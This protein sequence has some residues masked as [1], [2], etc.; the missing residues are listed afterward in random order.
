MVSRGVAYSTGQLRKNLL[1][2][3]VLIDRVFF[4]PHLVNLTLAPGAQVVVVPT[5]RPVNEPGKRPAAVNTP[6]LSGGNAPLLGPPLLL[7]A[8]TPRP[9]FFNSYTTPAGG[10]KQFPGVG[11]RAA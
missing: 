6:K 10:Y 9:L 5:L 11:D 1:E 2:W 4:I 3:Y 8:H 7:F